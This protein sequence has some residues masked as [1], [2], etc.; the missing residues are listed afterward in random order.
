MGGHE[1][2]NTVWGYLHERVRRPIEIALGEFYVD[3]RLGVNGHDE[4]GR[5]IVTSNLVGLKEDVEVLVR[6][7]LNQKR[8]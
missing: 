3:E 2:I 5:P 6:R 1:Y 8:G 7:T 4:D